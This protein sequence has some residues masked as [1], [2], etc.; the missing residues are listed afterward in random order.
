MNYKRV[1][2]KK[3]YEEVA[4]TLIELI[5]AGDLKPGDKLESVEKLA[6]SFDVGTS[7]IR[8]ALSGLRTMGL[9]V[10]R[11]GEGTFVNNFDPSK[12]QLPVNIAFLMK[13]EDI[14]ELYKVREILELGTVAQAAAV[15]EEEDL[16]ALE[17]AL[18]VMENAS[19]NEELASSADL[20]FHLAIANATH[21]KLLINLMSSVSS[22]ISETIQETRKVFLYSGNTVEDLKVEHRRIFEAI[23]NRQPNEASEAMLEHLQNVQ[24]RL[25]TY[26][27]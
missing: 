9:V 24:S 22:L 19:G 14:K 6:K 23:K 7:T 13:I 26:I 3:A 4:E 25:F 8:E 16:L 2:G 15:H 21:N 1:R 27:E 17:K 10:A 12:F 5:K 11:H 18:I 20:D